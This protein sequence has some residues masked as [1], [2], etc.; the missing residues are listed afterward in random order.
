[1][2][3]QPNNPQP[4]AASSH[5]DDVVVM[6]K[7]TS[8]YGVKGWLKVYSYTS[9]ID[10]IFDYAGWMLKLD[11]KQIPARLAQAR[12]HGK[13]LVAQLEGIDSR[14]AAQELA[15]AEILLPKQH[16]PQLEVGE[17]YWHQL[18]GLEV[19]TLD[20]QRL[21]KVST[22]METGANDVLVIKP[23]DDSIDEKERLVPYLPDQVVRDVDLTSGRM[24]VDWDP[25]F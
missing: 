22:L 12:R 21:G 13:G 16:L 24:S 14:E 5:D 8:P 20:G 4:T 17:Y 7:L 6:G 25:E 23:N 18:E 11:G 9:P 15:G 19:V 3:T 10:G 2:P 1:M